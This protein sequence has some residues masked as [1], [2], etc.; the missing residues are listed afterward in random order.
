GVQ[1]GGVAAVSLPEVLSPHPIIPNVDDAV[2]VDV[3]QDAVP[4]RGRWRGGRGP[5]RRCSRGRRGGGRGGRHVGE[6]H[7]VGGVVDAEG[8]SPA[9]ERRTV[10][11][12]EKF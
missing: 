8:P 7:R 11:Q 9:G 2:T 6:G 1:V 3:T 4:W 5:R 12:P 10:P